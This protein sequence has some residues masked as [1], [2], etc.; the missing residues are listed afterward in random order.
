MMQSS[1]DYLSG[2][3]AI[4]VASTGRDGTGDHREA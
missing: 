2:A 1:A 4:G 3:S